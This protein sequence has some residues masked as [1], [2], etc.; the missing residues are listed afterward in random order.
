M[1]GF[2]DVTSPMQFIAS[3]DGIGIL[4][5][6]NRVRLRGWLSQ[7]LWGYVTA[8]WAGEH[9]RARGYQAHFGGLVTATN[10]NNEGSTQYYCATYLPVRHR[11][12]IGNTNT[13][14]TL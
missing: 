9:R 5:C 8:A 2:A 7:L 12:N 10:E 14:S 6:S 3:T 13:T 11:S 4:G 1:D